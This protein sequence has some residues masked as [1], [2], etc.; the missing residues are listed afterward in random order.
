MKH[1][2][3]TSE[4][5]EALKL[6]YPNSDYDSLE[7]Y[8]PNK[9]KRNIKEIANYYGI[10]SN[11][12]GHRK[13]LTG[14]KFGRLTVLEINHVT[15][16]HVVYWKCL[17][18]CGNINI[19][20]TTC[21]NN[22]NTKSCGCLNR[23]IRGKWNEKNYV[24]KRFGMLIAIERLPNYEGRKKTYYKCL[25]DCGNEKIASGS[26]L[27]T[28]TTKTCGCISNNRKKFN[29]IFEKNLDEASAIY[30]IYKHTVP[31]GKMY[32]GITRQENKRRWQNGKGYKTQKKFWRAIQKYGWK[33]IKHEVLE[34]NLTEKEASEKEKIYIEQYKTTNSKY[35]YNVSIGGGVGRSLVRPIMQYYNDEPVNFFESHTQAAELLNVSLSTVKNYVKGSYMIEG[36]RFDNMPEIHLYDIDKSLYDIRSKEHLN[37]GELMADRKR[38]NTIKRNKEMS[39]AICKYDM[40]GH[41]ICRYESQEDARKEGGLGALNAALKKK[42]K[43]MSAGGFQWRYDNGDYSDIEPLHVNGRAVFQVDIGTNEII[44]KYYSLAEAERATGISSNQIGKTCRHEHK[45]AGGYKW[46]YYEE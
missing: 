28:G 45:T 25:C 2:R 22:G 33:N 8:F 10:K 23:E 3:Y 46:R 37:I 13:D 39:K 24:G 38:K 4:Q 17:C 18:E 6:Y 9:T 14:K 35:G 41:F 30:Q 11:N 44:A 12:P 29:E 26:S 34:S 19:V 5:I 21:L 16:K 27:V 20:S 15:E 7:K 1:R 32:I 43:S 42:G 36:Y 31:N 40:D